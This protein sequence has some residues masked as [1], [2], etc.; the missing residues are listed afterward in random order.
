MLP[1]IQLTI[2]PHGS[3]NDAGQAFDTVPHEKQLGKLEFYGIQGQ[4]P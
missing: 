1:R 2:S 4:I 3:D